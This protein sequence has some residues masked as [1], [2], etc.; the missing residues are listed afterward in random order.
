MA[1][2]VECGNC[3]NEFMTKD[4]H[5]GR[6]MRCP[7]CSEPI[8]IPSPGRGTRSAGGARSRRPSPKA[9]RGQAS[10]P[11]WAFAVGGAG[12]ML[13]VG[14]AAMLMLP[15]DSS[16]D[17]QSVATQP[18]DLESVETPAADPVS[19]TPPNVDPAESMPV[20][21]ADSGNARLTP[22]MEIAATST[23]APS[24]AASPSREMIRTTSITG[25]AGLNPS[26]STNGSVAGTPAVAASGDSSGGAYLT[27]QRTEPY[28][29]LADLIA[30]VDPSVVKINFYSRQGAGNGSGYIID[31]E[32]TLVTNRHVIEGATRVTGVF[33]GDSTEYPITGLYSINEKK[34]IAIL[35]IECPPEK[36][37]PLAISIEEPRKGTEL[38]AFGAP[39][40]LDFTASAG[41]LS[42]IRK[43]SDLAKMGMPGHEGL[44]FQHTVPISPGNSGGPLV[45]MKGALIGM[46]TMQITIGQNLNFAI[47]AA[48]VVE[49]LNRKSTVKP[50]ESDSVPVLARASAAEPSPDVEVEDIAGTDQA[51]EYLGKLDEMHVFMLAL[52]FDPTRQVTATV[53]SDV[54]DAVSKAKIRLAGRCEATMFVGMKLSSAGGGAVG[55]QAV[56]V[57]TIVHVLDLSGP[58]PVLYK[59]WDEEEKVGTVAGRAFLQGVVPDRLRDG[60]R[61]H[62]R[63]FSGAVN[64]NRLLLEREKREQADRK[65][66]TSVR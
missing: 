59:V 12:A 33:Q 46:N 36:L 52:G 5:A 45:N 56:T 28:A 39:L 54:E 9:K 57:T 27:S 18:A 25:Q 1:I 13:I 11:P 4:E 6:R 55:T 23:P 40:G 60:I 51:N 42:A 64:R 49:E 29:N 19:A 16:V 48:D 32:G 66:D 50:L 34:D 61:G 20:Q 17:D 7:E 41:I 10:L 38:V 35:K 47:S 30:A 58:S 26:A 21:V 15:G 53:R 8:Q 14:L 44:W 22:D 62:F 63:K 43:A 31:K 3:F 65:Q 2:R 37:H 24:S